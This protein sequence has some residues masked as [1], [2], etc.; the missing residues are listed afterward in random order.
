MAGQILRCPTKK[1]KNVWRIRWDGPRDQF[2]KRKRLHETA[3]EQRRKLKR[4]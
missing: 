2:G 4:F 3:G 1:N